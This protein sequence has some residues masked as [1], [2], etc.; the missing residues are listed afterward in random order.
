[1]ALF[2]L[3]G[4]AAKL[5]TLAYSPDGR[6]IAGGDDDGAVQVWDAATGK[7]AFTLKG[8]GFA[9]GRVAFSRDGRRLASGDTGDLG[10]VKVWDLE[11]RQELL[12]LPASGSSLIDLGFSPDGLRLAAA[13]DDKV[14]IW[15]GAPEKDSG[16]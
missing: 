11:S 6:W 9:V 14:L 1:L 5:T 10:Q 4:Q 3:E 2:R 7:R 15:D 12:S 16:P 13:F 8:H